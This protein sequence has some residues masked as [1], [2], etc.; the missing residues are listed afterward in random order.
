MIVS[1]KDGFA[2]DFGMAVPECFHDS[3]AKERF[4]VGDLFYNDRRGYLSKW[5]DAIR[6]IS[7]AIQVVETSGDVVTYTPLIMERSQLV[8]LKKVT[9]PVKEFIGWLKDGFEF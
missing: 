1:F 9:K 4:K 5:S 8:R 3:L 2:E 7:Y 6:H